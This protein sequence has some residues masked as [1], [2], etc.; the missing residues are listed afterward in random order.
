MIF[1]PQPAN[2]SDPNIFFRDNSNEEVLISE[3]DLGDGTIIY[4]DLSFWHTYDD[5]GSYTIRYYITNLY[6]CTDSVV[7]TTKHKSEL[8]YFYP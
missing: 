4:D 2:I 5:I 8:F 3:W 6:G 1:S 7:E